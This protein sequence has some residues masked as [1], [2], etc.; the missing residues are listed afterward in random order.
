MWTPTGK[1][2]RTTVGE[3]DAAATRLESPPRHPER[4]AWALLWRGASVRSGDCTSLADCGPA[5]LAAAGEPLTCVRCKATIDP[6][7]RWTTNAGMVCD[8]GVVC[9][10]CGG[11]Q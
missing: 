3:Y 11:E 6:A 10:G 4:W 8:D 2:R 9:A 5:V 7:D 1:I